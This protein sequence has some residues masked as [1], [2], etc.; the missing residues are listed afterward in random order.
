MKLNEMIIN[1]LVSTTG[2]HQNSHR[3]HKWYVRIHTNGTYARKNFDRKKFTE[4]KS[5]FFRKNDSK[6]PH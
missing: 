2:W 5:R 3:V 4:I 6:N 1:K